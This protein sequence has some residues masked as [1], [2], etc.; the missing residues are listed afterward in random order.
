MLDHRQFA[1]REEFDRG[2]IEI[3]DPQAPALVLLAG[4]MRRLTPAFTEHFE[5]RLLN[6]HPSLLPRYPG[7]DTH[8]RAIDAGDRWHGC[9]VHFVT[10]VLDGGPLIARSAVSVESD[11][12]ASTLAAKVL[13]KEHMLYPKV[14]SMCLRGDVALQNSHVF[15]CGEKLH[16]CL[17][18]TSPSP[19]DLS[20]SRMPSSA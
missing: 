9:S 17:L 11:Q 19:R 7:L 15:L 13:R 20:T 6:I 14:V 18:Y 16:S 3:I 12:C 4:F 5:G 1:T 8:Q 10:A 2:L